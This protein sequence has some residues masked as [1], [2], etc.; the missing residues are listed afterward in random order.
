MFFHYFVCDLS[1]HEWT[2]IRDYVSS[3]CNIIVDSLDSSADV[4]FS[5]LQHTV[6]PRFV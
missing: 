4:P 3:V 1:H 6:P 2:I 5:H